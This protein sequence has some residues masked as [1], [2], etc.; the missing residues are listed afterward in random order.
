MSSRDLD[1]LDGFGRE[2]RPLFELGR[3]G[4]ARVYLAESRAFGLRK[5]VV[6]K[7]LNSEFSADPDIVAS[8]RR[9]AELSA[10]MNHP[11]VV[12][13]MAVLERAGTP[14]IV[15]EYL[16]GAPFSAVLKRAK[17]HLP[18]RL[19]LYVLSQVL[20]GLH[21]FHELRDLDGNPFNA[22]H[23]D[24]SPQNVMI[25]HDGAVKVLDFG[26]AKICAKDEHSTRSGTVKGKLQ[27]MPPEQLFNGAHVD[28]R[29]DVFAVGVMLWEAVANRRMWEGKTEAELLR[30]LATGVVPGLGN[31]TPDV[32]ASV[33]TI[34]RRA[35]A[36]D[37]GE[38]YATAQEMQSAIDQVL[39]QEGWH[40]GPSELADF[41]STY[42]GEERGARDNRVRSSLRALRVA[43][44]SPELS[45]KTRIIRGLEKPKDSLEPS[46]GVF[47]L[48]F[49][50][51]PWKGKR[52]RIG[53]AVLFGLLVFM[54]TRLVWRPSRDVRPV[55]ASATE[56]TVTLELDVFPATAEMRLG[57]KLL[58]KGHFVG[59]VPLSNVA[60]LLVVSAPGYLSRR[61]ELTLLKD[62]SLQVVLDA[63]PAT[64]EPMVSGSSETARR[65]D[66]QELKRR[67]ASV[68]TRA[69]RQCNPPYRFGADGI[70]VYK[71]EC[72]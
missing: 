49:V 68:G 45:S 28:R 5:L 62:L 51:S 71:P 48:A 30:C 61:K 52:S 69:S 63:D 19:R 72:F 33:L 12:Q 14:A 39:V 65:R 47:E 3:G 18:L 37:R 4:M 66:P 53:A 31:A 11:N 64:T 13:V 54:G 46:V 2:Y 25:L 1:E 36:F 38:R 22:V 57:D 59:R 41:M 35:T 24:V 60:T 26:I 8:F 55:T 6:L 40:V 27:Y 29:A 32:P 21:H 16:D 70:K 34:V 9:E 67:K 44:S 20:A 56:R 43:K 50:R 17:E 42:L 10:Q 58:G 23:R 15:M 7:I